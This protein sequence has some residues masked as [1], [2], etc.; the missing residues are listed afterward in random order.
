MG[1]DV[2][3]SFALPTYNVVKLPPFSFQLLASRLQ[4]SAVG[5]N[6]TN[7]VNVLQVP[8]IGVPEPF[9]QRYAVLPAQ[10]L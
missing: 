2:G 4:L 8:L 3:I 10:A 5:S 6:R 1:N 7:I 9:L